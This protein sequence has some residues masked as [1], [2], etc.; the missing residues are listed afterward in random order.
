MPQP[1]RPAQH[2]ADQED[3]HHDMHAHQDAAGRR[4]VVRNGLEGDAVFVQA[5][6]EG[7]RP[8]DVG[9]GEFGPIV[10]LRLAVAE[11]VAFAEG[12]AL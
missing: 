10:E 6:E 8:Q 2:Q 7:G 1:A 5:V 12:G 3:V 11:V 9:Q 4:A